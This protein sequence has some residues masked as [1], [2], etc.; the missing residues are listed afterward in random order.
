[1]RK[2]DQELGMSREPRLTIGE[3]AARAGITP[4]A[5]RYYERV[6]VVARPGRTAGGFRVYS[7]EVIERLRF[8]KQAQLHGLTLAEIRELLSLSD[9]HGV[10][11]CRQVQRL[12]KRKLAELESRVTQLQEFCGTLEGYLAQCERTLKESPDAACVVV[13]RFRRTEE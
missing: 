4:D 9:R 3:L 8:I 2:R 6:G 13:E 11:Q 12:L 5:L 10:G 7:A 1:M